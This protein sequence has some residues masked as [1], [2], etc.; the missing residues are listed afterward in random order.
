VA[1]A[2]RGAAHTDW[3]SGLAAKAPSQDTVET[4]G[5]VHD[6]TCE[7]VDDARKLSSLPPDKAIVDIIQRHLTAAGLTGFEGRLEGIASVIRDQVQPYLKTGTFA[8]PFRRHHRLRVL[9]LGR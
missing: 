2:E 4:A 1:K 7:V 8:D 9:V 6:A 3:M 5:A